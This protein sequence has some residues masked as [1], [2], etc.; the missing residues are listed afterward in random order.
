MPS[1]IEHR[2]NLA[3]DFRGHRRLAP[4]DDVTRGVQHR[5]GLRAAARRAPRRPSR[6]RPRCGCARQEPVT[7][8]PPPTTTRSTSATSQRASPRTSPRSARRA[9]SSSCRVSFGRTTRNG[10]PRGRATLGFMPREGAIQCHEYDWPANLLHSPN[11]AAIKTSATRS[12]TR[13]PRPRRLRLA[14]ASP[15]TTAC[16]SAADPMRARATRRRSSA[17]RT[18]P[19]HR[20]STP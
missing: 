1:S 4:R 7:A 12:A 6:A 13:G 3:R 5:G 2:R 9:R 8:A 20:D 16:L 18:S 15:E 19:D 14:A 11:F 10:Y 17:T